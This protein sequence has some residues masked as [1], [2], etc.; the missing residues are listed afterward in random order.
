MLRFLNFHL[1]QDFLGNTCVWSG[2]R[3]R[4]HAAIA[5]LNT[6]GTGSESGL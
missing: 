6:L 1:M 2:A 3:V 4:C 5:A